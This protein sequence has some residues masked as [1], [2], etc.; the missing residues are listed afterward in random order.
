[1]LPLFRSISFLNDNIDR[2]AR[3]LIFYGSQ[4]EFVHGNVNKIH[5]VI[6]QEHGHIDRKISQLPIHLYVIIRENIGFLDSI[7]SG[8]HYVVQR[9]VLFVVLSALHFNGK[10]PSGVLN[11]KIKLALFLVVVIVQR[12]AVSMQ[13]LRHYIFI[14]C[15][16]VDILFLADDF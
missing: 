8:G 1:M 4:F 12:I 13:L 16:L 14:D 3:I 10:H 7:F 2:V 6:L 15:A 11:H 5:R 9:R